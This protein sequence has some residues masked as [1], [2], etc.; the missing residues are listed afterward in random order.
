M[1]ELTISISREEYERIKSGRITKYTMPPE[2][3]QKE[4][5]VP[6][7]YDRIRFKYKTRNLFRDYEGIDPDGVLHI[8]DRCR[9]SGE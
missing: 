6:L 5:S 9:F 7:D 1:T 8:G 3:L 4:D 2:E